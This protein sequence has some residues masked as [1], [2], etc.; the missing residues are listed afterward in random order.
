MCIRPS[1]YE[2]MFFPEKLQSLPAVKCK[3]FGSLRAVWGMTKCLRC[4]TWTDLGSQS[5]LKLKQF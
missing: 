1:S 5:A 4:R 2:Y 3:A